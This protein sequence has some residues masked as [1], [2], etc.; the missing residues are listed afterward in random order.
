MI[1]QMNRRKFLTGLTATGLAPLLPSAKENGIHI[2]TNTYPWSTFATRDG[3]KF[4]AHTDE[5]LADIARCGIAGYEPI[6]VQ[7]AE[8]DGLREKLNRHGLEM[9]SLYVNSELHETKKADQS[10]A[11]VL[12]IAEAA[13]RETDTQIIVTN[14]SPIRWGGPEDK[15]DGQLRTQAG[16]LDRLGAELR[17]MGVA[18]AYH[19]HDAELRQG[20]REFHHMLTA[21]NPANVKFCLDAIGFS[22]AAAIPKSLSSTRSETTATGLWSC[23][24]A[25][26]R[27]EFGPRCFRQKEISITGQCFECSATGSA[28]ASLSSNRPWRTERP[29]R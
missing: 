22:E 24:F 23:T 28:I 16:A 9:R 20:G 18:L 15:S 13:V 5:L 11:D 14:P 10:I 29:R 1:P 19:N 7:P 25:S 8:F 26:P 17:A 3:M 21:T 4:E 2:A 27:A 12:A 6:I